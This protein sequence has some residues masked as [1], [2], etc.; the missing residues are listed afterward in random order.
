MLEPN[1]QKRNQS[2]TEYSFFSKNTKVRRMYLKINH[3]SY[4][5]CDFI[6]IKVLWGNRVLPFIPFY[7]VLNKNKIFHGVLT[8][9][10]CKNYYQLIIQWTIRG[11]SH[12][13]GVPF[14]RKDK[15]SEIR[16]IAQFIVMK[17]VPLFKI[18]LFQNK[19]K[20]FKPLNCIWRISTVI[21]IRWKWEVNSL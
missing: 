3:N 15:K 17:M 12:R 1:C 19:F 4:E 8:G 6:N 2:L 5:I 7:S 10:Y 20:C 11:A 13:N 16:I 14:S 21:K 18:S 9:E